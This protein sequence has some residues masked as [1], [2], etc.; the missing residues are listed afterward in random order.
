MLTAQLSGCN[1]FID[2]RY[3]ETDTLPGLTETERRILSLLRVHGPLS[4]PELASGGGLDCGWA[5]VT[6]HVKRLE[7][8]GLLREAGTRSRSG[9]YGRNARLYSLSDS[10]GCVIALDVERRL[11]TA[12]IRTLGGRCLWQAGFPTP[13]VSLLAHAVRFLADCAEKAR[14]A[15]VEDVVISGLGITWPFPP[16]SDSTSPA[17]YP[18]LA[19]AVE[20][21]VGLPCCIEHNVSAYAEWLRYER[22]WPDFVLFSIRTGVG[23][24]V[25]VADRLHRGRG[26]AGQ[27][28]HLPTGGGHPCT[29]GRTGC[30]EAETG[31]PALTRFYRES[32]GS[33][34]PDLRA[35]FET[36]DAAMERTR[37]H[38]V[39]HLAAA[40]ETLRVVLDP[41]LYVIAGRFGVAGN[42][43]PGLIEA[44]VQG[45][46]GRVRYLELGDE[47]ITA[48]AFLFQRQYFAA[49]GSTKKGTDYGI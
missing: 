13:D 30:L 4:K 2:M 14:H 38:L 26:F 5:T 21:A 6:K 40:L 29:C 47:F 23:G 48:A 10:T 46:S 22:A 7:E 44:R 31:L 18:A 33:A 45:L 32:G 49:S 34:E 8:K 25:V 35:L 28:G 17:R 12:A 20:N 41:P 3:L 42:V 36:D 15:S 19:E 11:T 16:S 27:L 1:L 24:A 37:E 9:R 39:R 43:L